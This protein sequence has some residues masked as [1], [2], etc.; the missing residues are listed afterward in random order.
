M[1]MCLMCMYVCLM[2]G[3]TRC[4][5]NYFFLPLFPTAKKERN[6]HLSLFL[7]FLFGTSRLGIAIGKTF[8]KWNSSW[9]YDLLSFFALFLLYIFFEIQNLHLYLSIFFLLSRTE[10]WRKFSKIYNR[11]HIKDVFR[12]IY[13][14]A[15]EGRSCQDI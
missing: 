5:E 11:V 14:H 2:L 8:R 4:I 6:F 7:S 1:I 10:K 3:R 9:W 15:H 12:A 13:R